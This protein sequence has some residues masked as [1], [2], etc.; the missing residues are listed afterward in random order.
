MVGAAN[1]ERARPGAEQREDLLR[2]EAAGFRHDVDAAPHDMRHDVEA[3]AVAHRRGVQDRIAGRSRIDLGQIGLARGG[4]HAVGEH[5]A[6][7]PAGRARGVEQPGEIVAV[8]RRHRDRDRRRTAA[9][10]PRRRSRS[11]ARGS[12]GACGAISP[13]SPSEAKHTPRA[14]M[15][16]N[17]AE[18]G[19]VQLGVGRHRGEAGVPDRVEHFDDSPGSS[20]RRWRRGR[21]ARARSRA[22][23]RRA[24][25]RAPPSR[26]RSA[27]RAR[28]AP[29][30]DAADRPGPRDRASARGS[31]RRRRVFAF[32]PCFARFRC[33]TLESRAATARHS[34]RDFRP[35]GDRADGLALRS[36]RDGPGR[37]L[38]LRR[39]VRAQGHA[40][41]AGRELLAPGVHLGVSLDRA[42]VAGADPTRHVGCARARPRRPADDRRHCRRAAADC[43]RF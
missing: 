13:S 20:W 6:L 32:S 3:G 11:A 12:C 8:A 42:G 16:E 29:A 18:L 31:C 25:P 17:V 22:T 5:R 10:S 35:R 38:R 27:P 21:R 39:H 41:V 19:A 4:Q 7:R 26:R 34:F 30:R 15:F 14:G 2:L 37:R 36:R 23:R 1:I 43:D 28:R 24:A 9:R 33:A 40:A